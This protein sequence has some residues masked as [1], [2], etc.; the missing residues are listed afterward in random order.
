MEH[1]NLKAWKVSISFVSD[2]Y[3]ITSTF[4][5]HE[6]FGINSQM[7]RAAISIPSNI[8]EGAARNTDKD[9]I[10]FLQYALGSI[11]ELETQL[12]ICVD[13]QYIKD[14][15]TLLMKLTR[16]KMLVLGLRKYL[17]NK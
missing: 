11:A 15:E 16:I 2:I 10:K 17:S 4:P 6:I 5:K 8:S 3:K 12:I 7:R 14:S 1:K 9:F 13:L